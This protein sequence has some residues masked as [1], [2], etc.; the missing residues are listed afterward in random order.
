MPEAILILK[1]RYLR[2]YLLV[3]CFFLFA[4]AFANALTPIARWDV[5]PYQ[6]IEAGE[7]F[8]IGVVAFSKAR[9]ERVQFTVSG[10]G[11]SGQNPLQSISMTYNFQ[12]NVYEYWVP[13]HGS[14]FT[15]NGTFTVQAVVYGKDGGSRTLESLS[16][17][18]N[19]TG[20][21]AQPK[22]WV[23]TTGNDSTGAVN[24]SSLPFRTVVKAVS[25]IQAANGGSS[26]G[27][28]IYLEEGTYSVGGVS[29]STSGEWLTITKAPSAAKEKVIINTG[30]LATGYLKYD[31]I[32][33]QSRGSG[34]YVAGSS[35]KRLWTNNCR[36]IGS[37]RWIADSNPVH[38]SDAD[39]HF[40]TN[41]YTY[42]ADFAYREAA[43]VHG[44]KI[45]TIGNDVFQ[46]TIMVVNCTVD[47][48]SNGTHSAWH[49]DSYQVFST[50]ETQYPPANNRIIYNYK[51]TNAH[52]QGI[53]LRSD[54][55]TSTDNAF[56]NVLIEMREPADL[57]E[58]G[59]YS[60]T[61]F[62]K[63][64]SWD[65]LIVWNCTFLSGHS[66]FGGKFSNSS[67]VGNIF[68]Q[69]VD[70]FAAIGDTNLAYAEPG[71]AEN[72]EFLYNHFM[73]VYGESASCMPNSRFKQSDWP[74]PHWNAKK[75]DSNAAGS[76]TTGGGVMNMTDP[77]SN[78]F[79]APV[80]GSVLVDRVPYSTVPADLYGNSRAGKPDIGAV[81]KTSNMLDYIFIL[82]PKNK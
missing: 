66:S 16:L 50:D 69:Y 57:N 4:P 46:N 79:G 47:N 23:S 63:N 36:R 34:L 8:N 53:F 67:F 22:A 38:L 64:D 71:N 35:S 17:I 6:R 72:N 78:S 20:N 61:A 75:P 60:F 51:V 2:V 5:V 1:V 24:S 10:Q 59:S 19:A 62:A 80:T 48:I 40:S 39:N 11:Y 73:F 56:V 29:A 25:A 77:A 33:L 68:Y 43:L 13:L 28:I 58:T 21:L 70:D 12:T 81:E 49:A 18:V 42:N 65:H 55:A 26:N 41:D 76:A 27:A 37:G 74:C 14:D 82:F 9:I 31:S 15:T 54:I 32:T 30:Q 44:A 52:Y 45:S 7:T 3:S